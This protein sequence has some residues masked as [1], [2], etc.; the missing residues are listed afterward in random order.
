[1]TE[2]RKIYQKPQLKRIVLVPEENVL[3]VCFI[4]GAPATG[5]PLC[6]SAPPIGCESTTL[7][8]GRSSWP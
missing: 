5:N 4:T 3:V 8:G 1:M 2:Q 6:Q 7:A